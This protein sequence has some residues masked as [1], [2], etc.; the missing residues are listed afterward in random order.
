MIEVANGGVEQAAL[1]IK[2]GHTAACRRHPILLTSL[3]DPLT[4]QLLLVIA[5]R[6]DAMRRCLF[7]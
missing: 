5:L 2:F 7:T 4:W 1:V 3:L 6:S